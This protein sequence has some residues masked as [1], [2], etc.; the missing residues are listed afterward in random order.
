[1]DDVPVVLRSVTWQRVLAPAVL[2][3]F[4]VLALPSALP[5]GGGWLGLPILAGG[6]GVA[7]AVRC[8]TLRVEIGPAQLLLVNWFRTVRLPWGE[9][10]A[11][12]H[13][14]TGIWVRRTD[15]TEVRASAFEH[16]RRALSVARRPAEA[17]AARIDIMRTRCRSEQPTR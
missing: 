11:C 9:V 14:D 5:A 13:D 3:A 4:T 6:A 1:M 17:A 16:G 2:V 15:G 10:V 8:W 7:L 12:G